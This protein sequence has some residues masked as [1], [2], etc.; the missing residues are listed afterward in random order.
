[1]GQLA[2]AA[3]LAPRHGA[4]DGSI[5]LA[6]FAMIGITGVGAS[7][8]IAYPY[9]CLEKRYARYIGPR[10]SSP[11]WSARAH[12]WLKVMHTDAWLSMIIYTLATLAFYVL[13]AA[14]LFQHTGGQGLSGSAGEML[15]E[16][17]R[18][19]VPVLGFKGAM[20]FIAIGGFVVLFSTLFAATA[21][22]SRVTTDFLRTE[23]LIPF[24]PPEYRVR[25]IRFF[26]A[27]LPLLGLAL[28]LFVGDAVT[29]VIIGGVEQALTLPIL[30]GVAIY[31]RWRQTD[32]RLI[33][34]GI[35]DVCLW[36]SLVMFTVAA[37]YG[38]W[39]EIA[40][41]APK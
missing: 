31:L 8:L 10:E 6:A 35:W 34:R 11:A 29:M 20:W 40:K 12:G 4:P 24:N 32:R 18:M 28:Y 26:S 3:A 15:D 7:E 22:N 5:W 16:L 23:Q 21:G 33:K 2:G 25:W 37:A 1:M 13:G 9:W 19:Y 30:G 14:V 39:S 41:V 38:V 36:L 27:V 17:A